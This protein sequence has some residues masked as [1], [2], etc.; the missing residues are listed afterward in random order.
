MRPYGQ[1]TLRSAAA[2]FMDDGGWRCVVSLS[3]IETTSLD[4]R[5]PLL[6]T[7]G[8]QG[9]FDPTFLRFVE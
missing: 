4:R 9:R 1:H 6:E 2:V 7:S 5:T 3:C 8:N